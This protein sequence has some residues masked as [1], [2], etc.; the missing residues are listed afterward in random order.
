ML[1]APEALDLDGGLGDRGE[2][3][4]IQALV[5]QRAVEALGEAVLPGATRIA[6][7]RCCLVKSEPALNR[8]GHALRAIVAAQRGRRA[9]GGEEPVQHA[10]DPHGRQRGGDLNRQALAGEL[11]HDWPQ[12]ELGAGQTRIMDEIV[13]PDVARM[14]RLRRCGRRDACTAPSAAGLGDLARGCPPEPLDPPAIYPPALPPQ[15][16]PDA[17]IAVAGMAHRSDREARGQSLVGER[18]RLLVDWRAIGRYQGT[19]PPF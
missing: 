19:G 18:P 4:P 7:A 16:C 3:L 2:P 10:D 13:G 11:V 6:G 8:L 9:V 12:L 14:C 1:L 15:E 17:A 5:T